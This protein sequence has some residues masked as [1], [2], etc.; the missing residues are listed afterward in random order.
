MTTVEPRTEFSGSSKEDQACAKL[1][2]Q[3][4]TLHPPIESRLVS[5]DVH[6]RLPKAGPGKQLPNYAHTKTDDDPK[7]DQFLSRAHGEM[8]YEES[9]KLT[10]KAI[11]RQ[12]TLYTFRQQKEERKKKEAISQS[13]RRPV[14]EED[15]DHD[16][17]EESEIAAAMLEMDKFDEKLAEKGE[18]VMD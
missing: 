4:L 1:F 6:Q 13:V 2:W 16:R 9:I 15:S 8:M 7:L 3:S 12:E 11:Q 5:G 10:Q 17:E 18:I 14:P